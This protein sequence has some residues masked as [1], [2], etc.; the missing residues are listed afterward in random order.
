[1]ARKKSLEEW[2]REAMLDDEKDGKITAI[3]LVHMVGQSPKEIHTAKLI[4]GKKVE[5]KA[6]ADMFR[7]KAETYTQDLPGVHTFNLLAY[8]GQR[9]DPQ[10]AQPFVV[11]SIADH[12]NPSLATENP[13]AEG[14]TMQ[15]MCQDEMVFQQTYRRQAQ[16]DEFSMNLIREQ[17][18]MLRSALAENRDMFSIFKD[19][20]LQMATN[21][22][23]NRMKE[24]EFQRSTGERERFLKFLPPLVN[25]VLGKEIFPQSVEDT[26]IVEGIA[27]NLKEED[28]V[29]LGGIV[30]PEMLCPLYARVEKAMA[31]KRIE[32]E[33]LKAANGIVKRIGSSDPESD[34]AGDIPGTKPS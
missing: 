18:I 31:K 3:S 8:Y 4:D 16:L 23:G 30:P 7:G 33:A 22:H 10:A 26:A 12:N 11:N 5:P 6:L 2:I 13:T 24:L 25:T 29:K 32:Q 21:Q 19:V 34:A 27:A 17:N 14:K 20:M 9:T 15:R 1:M 28:L